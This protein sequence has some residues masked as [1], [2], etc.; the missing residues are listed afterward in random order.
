MARLLP[1]INMGSCLNMKDSSIGCPF[2]W[3]G[4]WQHYKMPNYNLSVLWPHAVVLPTNESLWP[5]A[6]RWP[7]SCPCRIKDY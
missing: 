4:L 5:C 6:E 2:I 7:K 3:L 1:H